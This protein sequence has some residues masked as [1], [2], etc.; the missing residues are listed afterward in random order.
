MHINK[1]YFYCF[2]VSGS[3]FTSKKLASAPKKVASVFAKRIAQ[4][5]IP[6]KCKTCE[7]TAHNTGVSY[8]ECSPCS[9]PTRATIDY[10]SAFCIYDINEKGFISH[11]LHTFCHLKR[12]KLTARPLWESRIFSLFY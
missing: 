4:S 7:C 11:N 5:A 3:V 12:F 1:V 2:L 6:S 9:Y 10:V 8:M